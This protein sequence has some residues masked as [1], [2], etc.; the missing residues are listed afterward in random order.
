MSYQF[1]NNQI[2]KIRFLFL[3]VMLSVG[4]S[5]HAIDEVKLKTFLADNDYRT[6]RVSPDGKHLSLLMLEDERYTLVILDIETMQPTAKVQYGESKNIEILGAEWATNELLRYSTTRESGRVEGDFLVPNMFLLSVD[7][8]TNE[9]IWSYKGNYENQKRSSGDLIRGFPAVISRLEDDD[10]RLLLFIRPFSRDGAD[11]AAVYHLELDSGDVRQVSKLPEYTSAVVSSSDG[12]VLVATTLDRE[13]DQNVYV[14]TNRGKWEPIEIGLGDFNKNFVAFAVRGDYIYAT[15]QE[16]S[17]IDAPTHVIRYRLSTG[18]WE[19]AAQIGF[20]SISEALITDDGV[21]TMVSYND[22]KPVHRVIDGS[23]RTAQVVSYFAK[24]YEGFSVS[25]V[26]ET[27]D[28][29]KIVLHLGSGAHAGEYFL[30]DFN[31]RKAKF[32]VAMRE[33]ID[34]NE[35]S[36]LQDASFTSS[37]GVT[38]PGWYQP[39]AGVEKPALIVDIHGGPHGP[40]QP[41]GFNSSWHIFNNMGYAV[42]GPNFRGSGGYGPNFEQSGYGEW[43]TRMI[44]DMYEG[45][46]ALIADG[47]VDPERVCVYG[48]SYGGYASTQSLVRHNDF[49]R[50]GVII[51]GIFDMKTQM[52]RTDIEGAYFGE[53]FMDLVMGEDDAKLREMSPIHNI[54][55][56]N[57]PML[58][59][60]G[61][62]DERTPFKGAKEFVDAL[63]KTDK[64]FDYHWYKKEGHG[65]RKLENRIDEW[66]RIEAFLK[67]NL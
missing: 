65:N 28:E 14:S 51:A 12:K 9:R 10:N 67:E 30:F 5:A 58:I 52:S 59:L 21:L 42:Y 38:I 57:A 13:Y 20:S 2:M 29:S 61:E 54:D 18:D 36:P 47:R 1:V 37:D 27:D 15:A 50:C 49:Y 48:G 46:Q 22:G 45:V 23:D 66:Q 41:F 35:L 34:G 43:G 7:G 55:K 56:I 6:V 31:T 19:D 53:N 4:F 24:N 44:D 39:P 60:H 64:K 3:L 11:R 8:K 40:Y 25:V 16:G 17:A 26:S 63:K 62:E 33:S 32:L